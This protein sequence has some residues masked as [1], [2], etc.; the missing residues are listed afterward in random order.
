MESP[1]TYATQGDLLSLGDALEQALDALKTQVVAQR[2]MFFTT[3]G[4][5]LA[6]AR[7][8]KVI[9]YIVKAYADY[10]RASDTLAWS[11]R[12][13]S[14]PPTVIDN[15]T[16]KKIYAVANVGFTDVARKIV[17]IDGIVT[18]TWFARLDAMYP[19]QPYD[20][21]SEVLDTARNYT[22]ALSYDTFEPVL[23]RAITQVS[24]Y[25]PHPPY[26]I[27]RGPPRA[28]DAPPLTAAE[29][30]LEWFREYGP[31][32]VRTGD[33]LD[34]DDICSRYGGCRMYTCTCFEGSKLEFNAVREPY[35][36][37]DY[38]IWC[39]WRIDA[40]KGGFRIALPVGGWRGC[41]C[42]PECA[43]DAAPYEIA[44]LSTD[45][46]NAFPGELIQDCVVVTYRNLKEYG[47]YRPVINEPGV[48]L[49]YSNEAG[50]VVEL[51]EDET[52][53]YTP[54]LYTKLNEI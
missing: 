53:E 9:K 50:F 24:P 46:S 15:D 27:A 44:P 6:A 52:D 35:W 26:W 2:T 37:V 41:Y 38:C 21:Y 4:A 49:P 12:I 18:A 13:L 32:N 34:N 14:V 47:V 22:P 39:Y 40:L 16:I 25:A 30:D 43:R 54:G 11:V 23:R 29:Q 42:S 7:P 31:L 19:G 20:V 17:T 10:F 3:M 51:R 1:A 8:G 45:H 5:G 48:P 33:L 28:A 36:F